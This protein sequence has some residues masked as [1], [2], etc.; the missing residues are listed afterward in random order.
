MASV[1]LVS[2]D[3]RRGLLAFSSVQAM[4]A[5]DPAA[6]GIP[7]TGVKVAAGALEHGADAIL[8][9]VA[10][11]V[12]VALDGSVLRALGTGTT[13]PLPHADPSVHAAVARALSGLDGLADVV[14]D[15]P[16]PGDPSP[17]DLLVVVTAVAGRMPAWWPVPSPSGS[18]PTRTWLPPVRAVSRW[19][20][21]VVQPAGN[22]DHGRV[23]TSPNEGI[24][25]A[26]TQARRRVRRHLPARL[27]RRRCGGVGGSK[28]RRR[29]HGRGRL[30]L[31]PDLRRLRLRPGQRLPTSTRPSPSGWSSRAGSRSRRP[32]ATGSRSSS[33][34]SSRPACS[35]TS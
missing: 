3:G 16:E 6:R 29:R 7:A 24:R 15:A 14:L 12:R 19:A 18:W 31:R 23:R 5:W 17:P 26:D 1:S 9:D 28:G 2:A 27:H 8:L 21:P 13:P 35:S 30:R 4:A 20:C 34:R 25:H 33:A 22:D 11:P 32:W 10:G